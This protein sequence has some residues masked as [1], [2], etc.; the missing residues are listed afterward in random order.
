MISIF[1][2]FIVSISQP[3]GRSKII[4]ENLLFVLAVGL[5]LAAQG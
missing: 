4:H 3:Y 1:R 5:M 2:Q